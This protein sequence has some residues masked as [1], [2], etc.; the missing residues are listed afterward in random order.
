MAA[1]PASKKAAVVSIKPG[2]ML[3][4]PDLFRLVRPSGLP[5][6]SRNETCPLQE[7]QPFR[8]T[9]RCFGSR[10]EIWGRYG[11]GKPLMSLNYRHGFVKMPCFAL[12]SAFYSKQ[13]GFIPRCIFKGWVPRGWI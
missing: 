8:T 4:A 13:A 1:L 6:F 12:I 11:R 10:Y 9:P 3:F 7:L 5:A 2:F